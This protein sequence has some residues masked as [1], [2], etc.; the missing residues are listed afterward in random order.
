MIPGVVN[1]SVLR[2]TELYN[3]NLLALKY[4]YPEQSQ[5]V[6]FSYVSY[7]KPPSPRRLDADGSLTLRACSLISYVTSINR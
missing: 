1:E 6:T 4:C 2:L 5:D 7:I 3:G